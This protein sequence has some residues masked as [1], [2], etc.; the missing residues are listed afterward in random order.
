MTIVG[1]TE[2]I[3]S[4]EEKAERVINIFGEIE[5]DITKTVLKKIFK[6][7]KED[8]KTIKE[9][10]KLLS[11]KDHKDLEDVV[12]NIMSV[13]GCVFCTSAIYDAL[14]NLKCKVITNGYGLCSSG[15]FWLL[16][17]GKERYAGK[18]TQ[19]LY[20]TMSYGTWYDKLQDHIDK[21]DH[22]NRVQTHLDGIII[23]K[24]DITKEMLESHRKDDWWLIFNEAV[25]LGVIHGE[26]K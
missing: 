10:E 2:Q 7:A 3:N 15:G 1:T 18:G 19:F 8:E 14:S 17:A 5:E 20:H 4:T 12:V 11:K 23:E 13:G 16:L 22:F 26:I 25:K 6:I 9:N 21:A 24:T